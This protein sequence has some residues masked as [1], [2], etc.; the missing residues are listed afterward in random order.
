MDGIYAHRYTAADDDVIDW[1]ILCDDKFLFPSFDRIV[2]KVFEE[3]RIS[4]FYKQT[5]E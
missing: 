3:F 5:Y 4:N 2:L 1:V